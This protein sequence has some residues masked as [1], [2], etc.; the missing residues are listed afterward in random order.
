MVIATFMTLL[1][2]NSLLILRWLFL[3]KEV[4]FDFEYGE[5]A[6][7]RLTFGL[8]FELY[9]LNNWNVIANIF[10]FFTFVIF[11]DNSGVKL[12]AQLL[13]RQSNDFCTLFTDI[14]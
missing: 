3:Q 7:F 1:C 10:W 8:F 14:L 5:D 11:T 6:E 2:K 9:L 12:S 4:F 13:S